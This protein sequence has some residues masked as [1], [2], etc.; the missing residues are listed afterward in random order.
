MGLVYVNYEF[1]IIVFVAMHLK[2]IST[3]RSQLC[4]LASLRWLPQK[5]NVGRC[6]VC[7]THLN[8][9]YWKLLYYRKVTLLSTLKD[10][11]KIS[12]QIFT[13]KVNSMVWCLFKSLFKHLKYFSFFKLEKLPYRS[14]QQSWNSNTAQRNSQ[15]V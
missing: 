3:P 14:T 9:N 4:N 2:I 15:V 8:E 5:E 1:I 11:L 10:Y 7:V 13:D 12:L 6:L